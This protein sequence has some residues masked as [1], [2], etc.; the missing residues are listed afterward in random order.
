MSTQAERETAFTWLAKS[1]GFVDKVCCYSYSEQQ[2]FS[3]SD[4]IYDNATADWDVDDSSIVESSKKEA[5]D[6]PKASQ[7]VFNYKYKHS[8]GP[9]ACQSSPAR[10]I[11]TASTVTTST[12]TTVVT[13]TKVNDRDGF[14]SSHLSQRRR[15]CLDAASRRFHH[16]TFHSE[17]R[18][19]APEEIYCHSG[20]KLVSASSRLHPRVP[21]TSAT[22]GY[23]C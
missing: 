7:Q 22:E 9:S 3:E 16:D 20:P 12:T 13:S 21:V 11:S 19:T 23:Q 8:G 10:S 5:N 15:K 17:R 14:S 2:I 1:I 6:Q 18:R 4:A